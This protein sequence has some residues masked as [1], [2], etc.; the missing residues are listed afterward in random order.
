[1]TV[2]NYDEIQENEVNTLPE[3]DGLTG[4]ENPTYTA[5]EKKGAPQVEA[6]V[7]DGLEA[8]TW[9]AGT[10]AKLGAPQVEEPVLL[11]DPAPVWQGEKKGAPQIEAPE[12]D[13]MPV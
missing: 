13:D 10:Q 5:P 9:N 1:M 11:D 4:L 6:P 8:P 2:Q 7:L 12:L 3:F